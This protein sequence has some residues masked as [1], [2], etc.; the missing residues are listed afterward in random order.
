MPDISER[1]F[2]LAIE[3]A[4][5]AAPSA[6]ADSPGG[7][8]KRLPE[9]YDRSLCLIPRDTVDFV[10]AIQPKEW[11]RLKQHYGEAVKEQFT[12]RL[13]REIERRARARLL[14]LRSQTTYRA[15]RPG[16]A[17]KADPAQVVRGT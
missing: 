8:L 1:S 6:A 13:A 5:L 2:E 15:I 17:D 16:R 3:A 4:L 11:T 12:R 10:L 14:G 9:D 7:Y